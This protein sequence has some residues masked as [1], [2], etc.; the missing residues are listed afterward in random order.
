MWLLCVYLWVMP[1]YAASP[2]VLLE[3]AEVDLHDKQSILRGGHA[4]KTQC[5]TCHALTYWRYDD[6]A[7]QLGITQEMMPQ[8]P[9]DAWGGHPPPDLSLIALELG[10]NQLYTYLTT[11]FEDRSRP[12]GANNL[13]YPNTSMPN[14]LEHLQG[15]VYL[16]PGLNLAVLAAS[17]KKHWYQVVDFGKAGSMH[18]E[19]FDQYLHDIVTFL[20][21]VADPSFEERTQLAPYVLGYLLFMVGLSYWWF[22]QQKQSK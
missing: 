14:V 10:V 18:P 9:K 5:L 15:K 17:E 12:T 11:Y 1:L 3:N 6:V 16:K 21:Y 8:W 7:E 20:A 2:V 13:A 19:E 22:L 4:F